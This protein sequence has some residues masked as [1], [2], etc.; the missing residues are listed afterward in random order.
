MLRAAEATASYIR[1]G[2]GRATDRRA[3]GRWLAFAGLLA[4]ALL[5]VAMA[6]GFARQ[7]GRDLRLAQARTPVQA[8]VTGCVGLASGTGITV[9]GYRCTATFR[10]SGRQYDD[11]IDGSHGLYEPG[12]V[13]AAR[14]DPRDPT[15]LLVGPAEA[16]NVRLEDAIGAGA[17]AGVLLLVAA[18]VLPR[19]TGR[20]GFRT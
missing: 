13:V 12:T 6:L 4:L 20:S 5:A 3:T 7:H 19:R 11:L 14:T 2:S 9:T 1:G 8:T 10:L 17:A 15:V 18:R 16:S